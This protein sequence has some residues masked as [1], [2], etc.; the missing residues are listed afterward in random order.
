MCSATLAGV[1]VLFLTT[2]TE[3]RSSVAVTSGGRFGGPTRPSQD[4]SSK[5]GK[6]SAIVRGARAQIY[7]MS[8]IVLGVVTLGLLAFDLVFARSLALTVVRRSVSWRGREVPDVLRSG[9]HGRI[10]RWRREQSLLR[11]ADR[12]PD[13]Y[14]A[15]PPEQLDVLMHVTSPR[16]WLALTAVAV[17]LGLSLSR[18]N[19]PGALLVFAGVGLHR[20]VR[21]QA[22]KILLNMALAWVRLAKQSADTAGDTADMAAPVDAS[23][24]CR[25][26][27]ESHHPHEADSTVC[28]DVPRSE[29][30]HRSPGSRFSCVESRNGSR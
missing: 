6:L 19:I 12:R 17:L 22:P 7:R 25:A 21:C 30:G 24:D 28:P 13:M 14:A 3:G 2:G 23:A 26:A 10:A 4:E 27:P 11:T 29:C 15:Y 18:A 9:D 5:S 16:T 8:S 1:T 20:V